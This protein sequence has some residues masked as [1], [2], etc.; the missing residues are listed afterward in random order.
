MRKSIVA[1]RF[2]VFQ[3]PRVLHG[4][5]PILYAF[6]SIRTPY[7]PTRRLH[8]PHAHCPTLLWLCSVYAAGVVATLCAVLVRGI[9]RTGG[10]T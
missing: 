3:S 7:P 6:D 1:R 2:W 9:D 5:A 10:W 8:G 4:V